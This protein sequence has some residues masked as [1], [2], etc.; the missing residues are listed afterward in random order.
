MSEHIYTDSSACKI[1]MN[2]NHA[3]H[4][5]FAGWVCTN[6][7]KNEPIVNPCRPA[8]KNFTKKGADHE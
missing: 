7:G 8:C 2:C 4:T 3:M 1:C 5:D 6:S